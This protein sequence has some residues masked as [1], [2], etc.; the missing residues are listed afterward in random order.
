MGIRKMF[1]FR[2]FLSFLLVQ[3]LQ[4]QVNLQTGS[5]VFSLPV[6][7]WKDTRSNLN[8]SA[9][10]QYN[11]GN[12][13]RVNDVASNIGHGWSFAVGGVIKRMQV[14]EPD[15]QKAWNGNGT[16]NDLTK[17]P[18]GYLYNDR[19][20]YKGV[21]TA[22]NRYPIFP[23]MNRVYKQHNS[24]T[25]D[26][27]LDYFSFQFN[28][29][30]GIFVLNKST[31]TGYSL[32]KNNLLISFEID[33]R[34]A[35]NQVNAGV[36]TT[37]TSFT[38]LDEFGI[39]F[40]FSKRELSKVQKTI[41]C[42]RYGNNSYEQ[43]K[44]KKDH[45]YYEKN[46]D[47]GDL[48]NPFIT[49]A[50]HLTEVE[51]KLTGRKV[52]FDYIVRNIQATA[53][54]TIS[55]IDQEKRYVLI[56]LNTSIQQIPILSA[57]QFPDGHRLAVAFGDQRVDLPGDFC[58]KSVDVFF[59]Q[60]LKT[61]FRLKN[62]YVIRN[63]FGTPVTDF[64]KQQAR[65]YLL[66]IRQVGPDGK[67]FFPDHNF[68]YYLNA[69]VAGATD[70]V[71][72]A[73]FSMFKDIWGYYNG[74]NSQT[75]WA[76][77]MNLNKGISDLNYSDATGL[78]FRRKNTSNMVLNPKA[79]YASLGLLKQIRFPAGG[80]QKFEY[81]QNKVQYNGAEIFTGGVRVSKVYSHDGGFTNDC[82]NL[83][84]TT[85]NYVAESGISSMW[86]FEYP[87]NKYTSY[88]KYS[89]EYKFYKW[90][91]FLGKCGYRFQYPGISSTS[92]S[93][94]LP[95]LQHQFSN[96]IVSGAMQGMDAASKVL[97][98]LKAFSKSSPD[99]TSLI[100]SLASDLIN[101][102][103]SC[104]VDISSN[105]MTDVY[106][107]LNLND[108]NPLPVQ[109]ARVELIQ[110][111]GNNG[112]TI[113]QFTSPADYAIWENN[114]EAKS[115]KQRYAFWAYGLPKST[116]VIDKNGKIISETIQ[117]YDFSDA[118]NDLCNTNWA[119]MSAY[120]GQSSNGLNPGENSC[121]YDNLKALPVRSVSQRI[122]DWND[123]SKY[124]NLNGF[125]TSSTAD[126]KL[127][128]YSI[129]TGKV[130]LSSVINKSYASNSNRYTQVQTNYA[131]NN[132]NYLPYQIATLKSNGDES[133]EEI[134]YNIDMPYDAALNKLIINNFISMP[135]KTLQRLRKAGS[136]QFLYLGG[137]ESEFT[138]IANGDVKV[139]KKKQYR[140][141]TP[142]TQ[143]PS[144][145]VTTEYLY[146][147]NGDLTGLIDEGGRT[148]TN[149]YDGDG[150]WL[151]ATV[152]NA[153][154]VNDKVFYAGFEE[155]ESS[156]WVLSDEN[157]FN[158]SPL[159]GAR[160]FQI[161]N[162]NITA[163]QLNTAKA[164]RLSFWATGTINVNG[165]ALSPM[166]SVPRVGMFS[167]FETIV[168]TGNTT[169]QLTG[170]GLIDE[171]RL[172]PE[173]AR[174]RSVAYDDLLGKT[175]EIDE[176]NRITFYTYD[177]LGRLSSIQDDQKHILK[178]YE[179]GTTEKIT[180]CPTVYTNNRIEEI[181]KRNNCQSGFEGAEITYVIP[182]GKYQSTLSQEDADR[183]AE[184]ELVAQGQAF[185]NANGACL[186]IY[187]NAERS[188]VFQKQDC[189]PGYIGAS[190]T[191]TVPAGRYRSLISQA[192]ADSLAQ[193]EIDANGQAAANNNP[194][195]SCS[196]TRE[197]IWESK[198]DPRFTCGTGQYLGQKMVLLY[199]VNP[200]SNTYRDSAWFP[201]GEIDPVMCPIDRTPNWQ[202]TGNFSCDI[203]IGGYLTG[204]QS[205]EEKDVNAS[206][207][208]YNNVRWVDNG[209]S[210]A[211]KPEADWQN[212]GGLVCETGT[213]GYASGYQ[214]QMQR[215]KNPY[216]IT[217]NQTRVGSRVQ[218]L[219]A[220]P[221]N[222]DW[223][224]PNPSA[225]EY[226]CEIGVGGYITGRQEVKKIDVNPYSGSYNSEKWFDAGL[227]EAV[228]KVLPDWKPTGRV[229][230]EMDDKDPNNLYT[231]KAQ[232]EMQD[233][234]PYSNKGA[235]VLDW[236]TTDFA[237]ECSTVPQ[238]VA[239]GNVK[240]EVSPEGYITGRQLKEMQDINPRSN[241]YRTTGSVYKWVDNGLSDACKP[242]A[243]WQNE[244]GLICETGTGGYA[245][246]Y[247]LQMQR[248][249]NPYSGTFNQ[250]RVGSRVQNLSAC[251]VNADWRLPNPSAPEYRCEVGV[252]GY[253]TGRLEV[254]KIDVNPY[255]GSYNSEKWF[256]AGLN[257]AVCKVLPDWKP[258][259]RVRCEMDD[260]DPNN[261]Y[262][263]KAQI[264][265]QD[266]NPYSNK[267]AI[268][269]DWVTTDFASEC[270]TVPQ[271]VAT[272]NV[273]CEVSPEGYITGRQLKEMQDINPRSNTYR[274]TGSVYKWVDNGTNAACVTV[275]NWVATGNTRCI[276][277]G[278][279]NNTGEQQREE[280]DVNPYN[281]ATYNTTRWQSVGNNTTA[282]PVPQLVNI[283][284]G[285]AKNAGYGIRLTN[286]QTGETFTFSV[287]P[288]SNPFTVG[289]V[290]QG[291]Y[292]IQIYPLFNGQLGY[293][294]AINS[295]YYQYYRTGTINFYSI[296][297]YC[298]N[299]GGIQIF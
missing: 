87:S 94:T 264:E 112:I 44:I 141:T 200:N 218:N 168:P 201:T 288:Y 114:D 104:F 173:N 276:K 170:S 187:F 221:V 263:G 100:I 176:N 71:V 246:G 260:K 58:M 153:H 108:F 198:D 41:Y 247:Q 274:T 299:C 204:R 196:I 147:A 82:N 109:Y 225:P 259:G 138:V 167:Y 197:P 146:N 66:G 234:N 70:D 61:R 164:Y 238:W 152:I 42:D 290:P 217:Y 81:E 240:C 89:P 16:F 253:N 195:L 93:V 287:I 117:Q 85:Y 281:T 284:L 178:Y 210:D 233:M 208:S 177:A 53:G 3:H 219:S 293:S 261:L 78:C 56:S 126:I 14:G 283:V 250:T 60:R 107:N 65:L 127:Q 74:S 172:L 163:N 155:N 129:Y 54:N 191:Y 166:V 137:E 190:L 76:E 151:T 7:Q 159:A 113:H 20:V 35:T 289:Q 149:I 23:E 181:F 91:P 10:F 101:L 130:Y 73:P 174:I 9:Q 160:C 252:G 171:L 207:T 124:D 298:T 270:S 6:L 142:L 45:V 11:S 266:M 209:L 2:L 297:M 13:L 229:R 96:P 211:C 34:L 216:S 193:Y 179:Y 235:I 31:R 232:I 75:Y 180:T 206:S 77:P 189:P 156:T 123:P 97:S 275:P 242:E 224:L 241:T 68:D 46:I 231:G 83:S 230:C 161:N 30:T 29:R 131:Y 5:A 256:D 215:D 135:V 57:V 22:L 116:T 40:K 257:E 105:T 192:D 268:V 205:R 90:V 244:G 265:M 133:I 136:N 28:G 121:D 111:Q 182:A 43:P 228:C 202:P 84:V 285:N 125:I 110:Q 21:S 72:P 134:S 222:A 143:L 279:N 237:S 120:D 269:L 88:N 148:V 38:I 278:N 8:L 36:R 183:K 294:A 145:V 69:G 226:R 139:S 55:Q 169:V 255:S 119:A 98:L 79:G 239:T 277:D 286:A 59:K 92:K 102:V 282:C 251:P 154:P 295:T 63:R 273:K 15:D 95:W 188:G 292:N 254:K 144:P 249:K 12:G 48:I 271:W 99:P 262:T 80:M 122:T 258:T 24:V 245:T 1:W 27:E 150:K 64:Q 25:A 118:K 26:T 214:I 128:F 213:G 62:S 227:N 185:A 280:R 272:G 51:D 33:E 165:T 67:S 267:G 52:L 199:D 158:P 18:N 39:S 19:A 106:Y 103:L 220:C 50:W 212:E 47:Q 184:E 223:R 37:I 140:L 296:P 86:G 115:M 248:D 203:G 175:A 291:M 186:Q 243:D 157:L 162:A 17:Y 194:G 236:V 4:A 32:E 49:T 132:R